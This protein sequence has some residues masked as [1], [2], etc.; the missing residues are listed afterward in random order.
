MYPQKITDELV[1]YNVM[2][3]GMKVTDIDMPMDTS[4]G[5]RDQVRSA[6]AQKYKVPKHYFRFKRA[7]IVTN[8]GEIKCL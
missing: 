2:V 4:Q 7:I 5:Y 8:K 3:D 6:L 1:T